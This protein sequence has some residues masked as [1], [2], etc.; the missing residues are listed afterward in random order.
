MSIPAGFSF[1]LSIWQTFAI[2][3]L[4]VWVYCLVDIVRHEFKNNSK[5]TW[6][7]I[8]FFLPI[9]GS[10]LYLSTGKSKRILKV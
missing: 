4:F 5:T 3:A 1:T 8:V 2:L 7:L 10:V 6:L 9:L